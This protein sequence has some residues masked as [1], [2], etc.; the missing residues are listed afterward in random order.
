M[1]S[2]FKFLPYVINSLVLLYLVDTLNWIG[3]KHCNTIL[4]NI[5]FKLDVNRHFK[6]IGNKYI[7]V[8]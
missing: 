6:H 1:L 5:E 8:P 2:S 4:N 3:T 7:T